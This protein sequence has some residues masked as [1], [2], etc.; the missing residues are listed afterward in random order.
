MLF[1]TIKLLTLFI[2][3]TQMKKKTTYHGR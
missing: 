1:R 2:F 3:F